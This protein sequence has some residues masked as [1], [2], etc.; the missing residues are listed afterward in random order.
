MSKQIL[1]E[2]LTPIDLIVEVS[3]RRWEVIISIKHPAMLGAETLVGEVLSN[4]DQIRRSRR[5]SKVLLF[6][7]A[8]R[9]K[10]WICAVVKRLNDKATLV[11]AY[12]TNA[13]K[14]GDV[15]WTR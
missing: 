7:K 5:D 1:F 8:Q 2:I 3:R 15:I 6:Y 12:P 11:T 14:V 10:R 4:P 13:I 9:P